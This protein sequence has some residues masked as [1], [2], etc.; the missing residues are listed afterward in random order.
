MDETPELEERHPRQLQRLPECPAALERIIPGGCRG[1][2]RVI[3]RGRGIELDDEGSVGRKQPDPSTPGRGDKLK[4]FC[5]VSLELGSR[6]RGDETAAAIGEGSMR[7]GQD[8]DWVG[9]VM[10]DA[11]L[12][13]KWLRFR[14]YN[15]RE[16]TKRTR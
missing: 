16:C 11:I 1:G 3:L 2:S 10:Q 8:A 6:G 9:R 4:A 13:I 15:L 12:G 14:N 7:G 5:P